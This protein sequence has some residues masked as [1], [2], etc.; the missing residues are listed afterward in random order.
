MSSVLAHFPCR[1]GCESID[2][3]LAYPSH[4]KISSSIKYLKTD[5]QYIFGASTLPHSFNLTYTQKTPE[6]STQRTLS[7]AISTTS[8]CTT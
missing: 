4:P 8:A 3:K 1:N 5:S 7:I 6:L 2:Y